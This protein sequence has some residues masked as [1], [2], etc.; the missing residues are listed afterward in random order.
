MPEKPR[1]S[2]INIYW[3]LKE[4]NSFDFHTQINNLNNFIKKNWGIE[5]DNKSRTSYD[6]E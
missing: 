5:I 2:G 4:D 6:L 3:A 1:Q